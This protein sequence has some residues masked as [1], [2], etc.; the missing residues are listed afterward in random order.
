MG[1]SSNDQGIRVS[2]AGLN[3]QLPVAGSQRVTVCPTT[4]APGQQN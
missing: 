1:S 3:G 2:F 4:K